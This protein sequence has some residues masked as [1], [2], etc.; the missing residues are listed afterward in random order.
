MSGPDPNPQHLRLM[1][2]GD[3]SHTDA[4]QLYNL[5]KLMARRA[6]ASDLEREGRVPTKP[7]RNKKR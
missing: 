1:R 3:E 5:V 7:P 6:A 4:S 2:T